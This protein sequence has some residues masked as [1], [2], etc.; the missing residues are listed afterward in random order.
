MS[1]TAG[2]YISIEDVGFITCESDLPGGKHAGRSSAHDE[3]SLH[4]C[5]L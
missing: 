1:Q 4:S 5:P 3:D 2:P